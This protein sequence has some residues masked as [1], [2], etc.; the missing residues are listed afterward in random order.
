MTP[1]LDR[2]IT[3]HRQYVRRTH[4]RHQPA[5]FLI[6]PKDDPALGHEFAWIRPQTQ[7]RMPELMEP[8]F[9]YIKGIAVYADPRVPRGHIALLKHG[10]V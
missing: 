5:A 4:G 8:C 6:N 7:A 2:A 3:A 9:K 1:L 10:A